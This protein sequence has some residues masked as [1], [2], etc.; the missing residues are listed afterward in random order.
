MAEYRLVKEFHT[1]VLSDMAKVKQ[2][3]DFD[4][5]QQVG[6]AMCHEYQNKIEQL[7]N[8]AKV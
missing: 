5:Q 3:N 2:T 7:K 4:G 1:L 6:C 8:D